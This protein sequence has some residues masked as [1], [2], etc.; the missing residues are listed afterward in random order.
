MKMYIPGLKSKYRK[1]RKAYRENF[2]K[3][4]KVYQTNFVKNYIEKIKP[5][6]KSIAK[7]SFVCYNSPIESKRENMVDIAQLVRAL[8]CGSRGRGFESLY[9]PQKTPMEGRTR[10]GFESHY[11]PHTHPP[12][13]HT[14][15]SPSGKAPDFDSGIR[16]FKSCQPSQSKNL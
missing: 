16:R 12:P 14:G 11:P 10:R 8:D 13:L 5:I 6:S 9:P 2:A 7:Q 3:K 4:R 15:L 1:K